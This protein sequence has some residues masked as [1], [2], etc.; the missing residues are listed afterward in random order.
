MCSFDC[1]ETLVPV[2]DLLLFDI[3]EIDVRRHKKFTGVSN[4]RILENLKQLP[5]LLGAFK[6]DLWIRTPIIPGATDR[7][8]TI[9]SIGEFIVNHLEGRVSR[10]ELCAFNNL[11][12]EK[13]TRLGEE[14]A[15]AAALLVERKKMEALYQEAL[16]TGLGDDIV[17][18]SGS[19]R[20]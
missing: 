1:L 12:K 16:K 11:G 17:F 10:W 2:T 4:E 18:W 8:E 13:Y 14:W 20:D 15:Y 9:R 7:E 19:V 3:K 5:G 6:T